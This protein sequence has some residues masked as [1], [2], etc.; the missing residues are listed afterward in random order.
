MGKREE[1][2]DKKRQCYKGYVAHG[3]FEISGRFVSDVPAF[4][5]GA[6]ITA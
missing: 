2:T 1:E 5:N 6:V 3:N 4:G